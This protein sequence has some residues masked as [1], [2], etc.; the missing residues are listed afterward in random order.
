MRQPLNL[1][2]GSVRA[3]ATL[4]LVGAV[5]GIAACG[6]NVPESVSTLAAMAVAYYFKARGE[7]PVAEIKKEAPDVS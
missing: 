3:I 6:R 4:A 2:A 5:V 7:E 1:P